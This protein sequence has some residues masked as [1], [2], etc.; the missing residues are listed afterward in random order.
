MLGAGLA[1]T[2]ILNDSMWSNPFSFGNVV[3][4]GFA[5]TGVVIKLPP[6]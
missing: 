4:W 6:V 5:V 2:P 1:V 3:L